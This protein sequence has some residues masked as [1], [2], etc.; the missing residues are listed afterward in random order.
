MCQRGY[1][2]T[3]TE[4]IFPLWEDLIDRMDAI[5]AFKADA[6]KVGGAEKLRALRKHFLGTVVVGSAKGG[7]ADTI[8]TREVIDGQQRITT[9][10]I[11]LLAFRDVV[12]PLEDEG[13]DYS[14]KTLTRNLGKYRERGHH[15]KVWPT[16]VGRD[17]MQALSDAGSIEAVCDRFPVKGPKKARYERP[18][19]GC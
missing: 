12:K 8:P 17:V 7:G 5:A 19:T 2:W 18:L 4:Q 1:V 13:L 9:L 11:L 14:L 6:E 3:L 10:Q 16:N 15:L